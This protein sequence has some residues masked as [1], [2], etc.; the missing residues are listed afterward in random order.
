[1]SPRPECV[2]AIEQRLSS[3]LVLA[4]RA[5]WHWIGAPLVV[6]DPLA[7]GAVR[8]VRLGVQQRA[9][10][11][12]A[13]RR[14]AVIVGTRR[15]RAM[16]NVGSIGRARGEE[17][18]GAPVD[19]DVL[20]GIAGLELEPLGKDR[21][22]VVQLVVHRQRER[23]LRRR[24]QVHGESHALRRP[25]HVRRRAACARR[26]RKGSDWGSHAVGGVGKRRVYLRG[27]GAGER[28]VPR[29]AVCISSE[30]RCGAQAANYIIDA[31]KAQ[32]GLR[33][34]GSEHRL[35]PTPVNRRVEQPIDG[36]KCRSCE[37]AS[38]G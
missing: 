24:L 37:E 20:A 18:H 23:W 6:V 5:A 17:L 4:R 31:V 25:A 27:H 19:D 33:R 2:R 34:R 9:W 14:R 7:K 1:M 26:P 30:H 38:R 15:Q 13:C 35:Q 32:H 8:L 3:A 11:H 36:S 16:P 10:R 22:A 29:G 12:C 28:V 21:R